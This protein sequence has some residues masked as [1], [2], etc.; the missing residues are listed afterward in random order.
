MTAAEML[1][2]IDRLEGYLAWIND[3]G[4]D[5]T[6]K[7]DLRMVVDYLKRVCPPRE[8]VFADGSGAHRCGAGCDRVLPDEQ[9]SPLQAEDERCADDRY[10]KVIAWNKSQ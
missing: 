5:G 8:S 10:R 6:L 9:C 2:L 1:A 3:F 4:P 7:V